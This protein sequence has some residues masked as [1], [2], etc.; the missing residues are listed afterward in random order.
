MKNLKNKKKFKNPYDA[1]DYISKALHINFH[2]IKCSGLKTFNVKRLSS[3]KR[4]KDF[5]EINIE[6]KY[7]N[8][9]EIS[10]C[11]THYWLDFWVGDELFTARCYK[12]KIK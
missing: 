11:N 7:T 10:E 5:V 6:G 1:I 12:N 8:N 4:V 2:N 9:Y 3:L